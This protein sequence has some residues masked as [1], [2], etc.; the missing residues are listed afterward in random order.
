MATGI[1]VKII[2]HTDIAEQ[3]VVDL[4]SALRV[5]LTVMTNVHPIKFWEMES[6]VI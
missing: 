6:V 2:L 4:L 3:E 5:Q 1:E